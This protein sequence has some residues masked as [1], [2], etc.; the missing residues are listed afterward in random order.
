MHF[1]DEKRFFLKWGGDVM[2]FSL[3]RC[4]YDHKDTKKLKKSRKFKIKK[5]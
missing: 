2:I 4:N 5:S 3:I 1:L